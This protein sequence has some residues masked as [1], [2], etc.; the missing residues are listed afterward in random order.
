[1]IEK[2]QHAV[3][4]VSHVPKLTISKVGVAA[5]FASALVRHSYPIISRHLI[6]MHTGCYGVEG[7]VSRKG[8]DHRH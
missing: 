5:Q 8:Y 6:V 3:T 2:T 7:A 4:R 1:M